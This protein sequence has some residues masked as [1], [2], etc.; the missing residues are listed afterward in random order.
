MAEEE[1]AVLTAPSSPPLHSDHK[2]KHDELEEQLPVE[3]QVEEKKINDVVEEEK[4]ALDSSVVDGDGDLQEAKRARVV[5][6]TP[7]EPVGQNG[8]G[9]G[10]SDGD[11]KGDADEE[12]GKS[13]LPEESDPPPASEGVEPTPEGAQPVPD[14]ATEA[15]EHNDEKVVGEGADEATDDKKTAENKLE[16]AE[17]VE[18]GKAEELSKQGDEQLQQDAGEAVSDG[19]TTSRKTEVPNDKVGVLIGKGGD[20]I[21]FLQ[22]NSGAKIQIMR[23]ADADP[24]CTTRPVEII[25]TLASISKAEKLIHAVIA[26]MLKFQYFFQASV[27]GSPS[28]VARGHPSAQSTGVPDQLEMQ[29][30][31]EKVGLIIGKGGETIKG[32]QTKTGARI[33]LIPQH[34]PEGDGSK[35]RT[36]RVT[37]DRAQIEM[38]RELIKEVMS[39][40]CACS[41]LF[42]MAYSVGSALLCWCS[43]RQPLFI[44]IH[45]QEVSGFISRTC[46][47]LIVGWCRVLV[48][49][50][51]YKDKWLFRCS[52]KCFIVVVATGYHYFSSLRRLNVRQSSNSG[53]YN[54]QQS[55]RSRGPNDRGHYGPRGP[56]PAQP[57][58]YDYHQRGPYPP[59]GMHYPPPPSYGN[60]PPQHMG[61]RSN[62]GSSWEQRP[63]PP[64]SSGGGYDYYGG[65]RGHM[66]DH[67]ASAPVSGHHP[68]GPA[69]PPSSQTNYG[70]GQPHSDYGNQASYSQ[71]APQQSYDNHAPMHNHYGHASSQPGYPPAAHQQYSKQPSYGMQ[72][73]PGQP[74]Q[75]YPASQPYG[76]GAAATQQ[77]YPYTSTA[78]VQQGYPPYGAAAP[79]AADGYNSQSAPPASGMGYPPQSGQPV[80]AYGQQPAQQ[81]YPQYAQGTTAAAPYGSYP[82][83]QG[84]PDQAASN[85]AG[86]GYQTQD[87]AYATGAAG[88]TYGAAQPAAGQQQVYAQP[89]ATPAQAQ[90]SYDQSVPQSGSYAAA[91]AAAPGSTPA[92]PATYPQYD[93]TQMHAA[94]H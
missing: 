39:Q 43:H 44:V 70:Y 52:A 83:S 68:H 24:R 20:T 1:V 67:P 19:Q 76:Q 57:M 51:N 31:N 88:S 93:S 94:P 56:H 34:L 13:E 71:P 86:Y 37:G 29:V 38:A 9:E 84:Y 92:Q 79:T 64:S 90:P 5:D 11:A 4:E 36:V 27:G 80:P 53:G 60:Y 2:R 12:N 47:M 7:D 32:L 87:P 85:A 65:P 40:V 18:S 69:P 28:L 63:P 72:P 41:S 82:S 75:Q 33:Q 50:V 21:R 49:T 61:Q 42:A 10:K 48:P 8:F 6:L 15:I 77:Q 23:D 58:P 14:G 35:E 25:G 91:P 30:P 54:Q 26:E 62:Y 46:R 22:Q 66:P 73:A 59:H 45:R 3:A 81:G 16:S 89:T 78:P 55:Y 74:P 17:G